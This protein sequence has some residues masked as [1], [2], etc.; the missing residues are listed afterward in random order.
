[1]MSQV[2]VLEEC[3]NIHWSDHP[4][5]SFQ[6]HLNGV[7]VVRGEHESLERFRH[8]GSLFTLEYD[9]LFRQLG[10]IAVDVERNSLKTT[11]FVHV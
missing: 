9:A 6:C 11:L 8:D 3:L 5:Q 4:P 1:M 10:G 7:L 2:T